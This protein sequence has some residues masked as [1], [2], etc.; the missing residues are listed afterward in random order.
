MEAVAL[1]TFA[2][3]NRERDR[4][5]HL[6]VVLFNIGGGSFHNP[7][8]VSQ[9]KTLVSECGAAPVIVLADT[10]ELHE[11]FAAIDCGAKGFIPST[12]GIAICV[13]AISLVMAGGIFLP[14]SCVMNASRQMMAT[15][16]AAV[17]EESMFTSRQAEVVEGL[18]R[19]KANKIIAY[20]LNMCEST[21]K[22]HVRNV[23]RKL[24]ATNRT[25]VVYK[26]NEM[27]D[28]EGVSFR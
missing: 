1:G 7:S 26:L 6:A 25:E 14:A 24:K 10:D 17:R 8:V 11:I 16:S 18:K 22:V 23:M 13:E 28:R 21:V 15:N 2:E 4:H 12:L 27:L 19:G 3:W 9:A 5:P 20:E